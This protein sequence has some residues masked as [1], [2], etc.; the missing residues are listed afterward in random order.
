M[1][2]KIVRYIHIIPAGIKHIAGSNTQAKTNLAAID[3][4]LFTHINKVTMMIVVV[5]A[6]AVQGVAD[7]TQVGAVT[8]TFERTVAVI[9]Y[10]AIQV[11]I[12]IIVEKYGLGG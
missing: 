6:V 5:Q 7:I 10:K 11:A 2:K 12:M 9:Q 1:L 3:S 8:K 4:C